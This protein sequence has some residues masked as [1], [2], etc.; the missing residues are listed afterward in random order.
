M[1]VVSTTLLAVVVLS[2]CEGSTRHHRATH[3]TTPPVE[4]RQHRTTLVEAARGGSYLGRATCGEA[5]QHA[6][7]MGANE[8]LQLTYRGT[9]SSAEPLGEDISWRWIGPSGVVLDTNELPA[10]TPNGAVAE[11][12]WQVRSEGAGR[13]VLA[14][15]IEEGAACSH[16]SYTLLMH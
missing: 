5:H 16:L 10:P 2:G 7:T 11:R 1:R 8:S 4:A 6:I 12:A 14:L 9:L 15:M 3:A 13:Y